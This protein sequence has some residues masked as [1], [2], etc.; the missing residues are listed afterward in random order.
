MQ[1]CYSEAAVTLK[2]SFPEPSGTRDAKVA[3]FW[4]PREG[5]CLQP[6]SYSSPYSS[7][8][9]AELMAVS[10]ETSCPASENWKKM[11]AMT[12]DKPVG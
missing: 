4:L 2:H 12:T 11:G 5:A 10:I 3:H 7:V 6:C 9:G 1:C 8:S